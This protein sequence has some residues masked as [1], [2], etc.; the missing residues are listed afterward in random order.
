MSIFNTDNILEKSPLNS[1]IKSK[2]KERNEGIVASGMRK[3]NDSVWKDF[4]F[5]QTAGSDIFDT[6]KRTENKRKTLYNQFFDE[7]EMIN[8]PDEEEKVIRDAFNDTMRLQNK[9]NKVAQE[10]NLPQTQEPQSQTITNQSTVSGN[11]NINGFAT[12]NQYTTKIIPSSSIPADFTGEV[13]KKFKKRN[14]T[15]QEKLDNFNAKLNL[16]KAYYDTTDE[17]LSPLDYLSRF[18]T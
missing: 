2:N 15:R 14:E 3:L 8:T 11:S 18:F 7:N 10:Y 1:A 12:S 5:S 16:Y 6:A 4:D 17:I 9:I 13:A